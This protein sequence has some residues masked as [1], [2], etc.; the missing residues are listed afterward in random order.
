MRSAACSRAAAT[1]AALALA[2]C[3]VPDIELDAPQDRAT[4]IVNGQ[5]TTIAQA[6][7]ISVQIGGVP[8]LSYDGPLGCE[9]QYFADDDPELYF[10]YGP[11][12]AH[13]LDGNR[14]YEFSGPPARSSD[15][16]VWSHTF[17]R[18]RVTVLVNCP[19]PRR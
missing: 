9:G 14:L 1:L 15:G 4:F 18:D 13:L 17:G 3:G 2:G 10:R 7:R 5:R 11:R 19:P 12:V 8:E 6:G 16:L